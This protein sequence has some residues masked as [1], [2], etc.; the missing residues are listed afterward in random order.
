MDGPVITKGRTVTDF[1]L[2]N[3]LSAFNTTD[4]K[5]EVVS[6]SFSAGAEHAFEI[7]RL[8]KQIVSAGKFGKRA[9][10]RER[11]PGKMDDPAV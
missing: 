4:L 7:H 2:I 8:I 5:P 3:G 1:F 11:D 9:G 10:L 6:A